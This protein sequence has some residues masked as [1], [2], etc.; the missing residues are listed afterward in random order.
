MAVPKKKKSLERVRV[1]RYMLLGLQN[2]FQ[3]LYIQ[4]YMKKQVLLNKT[5][6]LNKL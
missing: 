4:M 5:S 3:S 2:K 1:R 6:Y